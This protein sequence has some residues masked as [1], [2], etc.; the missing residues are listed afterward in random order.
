M[1]CFFWGYAL[2]QI[3]AGSLADLVDGKKFLPF[4]TF[5]WSILTFCTP[6]L[7]DFAYWSSHPI[8]ILVMVRVFTGVGQGNPNFK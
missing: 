7:F 6:Q 2:T 5:I 4:T 3:I 1:S 8:L